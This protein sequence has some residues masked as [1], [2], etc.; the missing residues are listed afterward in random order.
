MAYDPEARETGNSAMIIGI[1]A[2]VLVVGGALAY[3][4]TRSNE[5]VDTGS[6]TIVNNPRPAAPATNTVVVTPPVT[7]PNTV[8]VEKQVPVPVPQT[9]V[10]TR[11]TKTTTNTTRVLPPPST[12][13]NSSPVGGQPNVTI[14]NNAPN[15]A[16]NGAANSAVPEPATNSAGG[17]DTLPPPAQQ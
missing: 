17:A 7:Q 3:F 16:N 12:G 5:P 15:N 11:D 8:V 6:T 1:V 13:E 14:N 4:L 10:I 2:L 9:K